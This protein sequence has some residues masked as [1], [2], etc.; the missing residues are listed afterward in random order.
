MAQ[1]EF[2]P[3][4]GPNLDNKLVRADLKA[5][6]AGVKREAGDNVHPIM[7]NKKQVYLAL[8]AVVSDAFGST[9]AVYSDEPGPMGSQCTWLAYVGD[10][11]DGATAAWQLAP[12]ALRAP[13]LDRGPASLTEGFIGALRLVS[14]LATWRLS[15]EQTD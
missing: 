8:A 3:V 14:E 4:T 9:Y 7:V 13:V 11:P 12:L 1:H 6:R 15:Q 10:E 5:Y 2:M